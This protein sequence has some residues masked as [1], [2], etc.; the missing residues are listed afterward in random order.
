[1]IGPELQ[2]SS[3]PTG[4]SFDYLLRVHNRR[5]PN[6][7]LG[8]LP[9]DPRVW[10]HA[11]FHDEIVEGADPA[12]DR[13]EVV[14]EFG[15]DFADLGQEGP[16]DVGEVVVFVVVAHI[17][18]EAVKKERSNVC[19]PRMSHKALFAR[20]KRTCSSTRSKNKSPAPP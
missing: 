10:S 3:N 5:I 15:G 17:E 19:Q 7:R 1:M 2:V 4:A 18:A 20:P 13:L 12:G 6:R 9:L 8:L 16:G 11:S 14:V